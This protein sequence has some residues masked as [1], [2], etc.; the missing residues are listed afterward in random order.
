MNDKPLSNADKIYKENPMLR[1][2]FAKLG[3]DAGQT[4]NFNPT[5]GEQIVTT[6]LPS[7][8]I[9]HRLEKIGT[10]SAESERNS[11]SLGEL[12]DRYSAVSD[13]VSNLDNIIESLR[14]PNSKEVLGPVNSFLAYYNG[15]PEEQDLLGQFSTMSGNIALDAAKSIKGA[16]TGRDMTLLNSVKGNVKDPYGVFV[17]KAKAMSILA[18]GVQARLKIVSEMQRQGYS[19][20]EAE[21]T[22]KKTINF[23]GIAKQVEK[24]IRDAERDAYYSGLSQ[25]EASRLRTQGR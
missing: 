12:E 10:S 17:G 20:I 8:Q 22:A 21:E 9:E 14:N 6:K 25:E 15:S 1:K 3:F 16:F 19:K 18:G 11:K 23:D 2:Y 24:T 5:T 13:D 4:I 7:G